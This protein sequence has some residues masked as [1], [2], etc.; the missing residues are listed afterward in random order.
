MHLS[1]DFL[2]RRIALAMLTIACAVTSAAAA[3]W[4]YWRGPNFDGTA[5]ATAY[6]MTGIPLA[7]TTA[8]YSGNGKTLVDL[9]H[10]LP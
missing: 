3:D 6:Q 8:T 2:G 9:A 7:A 1:F 4:P 10:Q 5:E